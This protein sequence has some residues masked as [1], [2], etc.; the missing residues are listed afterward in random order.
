M[1]EA[2]SKPCQ[3]YKMMRHIENFDIEQFIQVFSDI[4]REIQ[5]YLGQYSDIIKHIEEY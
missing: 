2:H 3:I 4:L 1:P 5:Q